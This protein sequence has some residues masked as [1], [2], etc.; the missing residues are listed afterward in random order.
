[1]LCGVL[2]CVGVHVQKADCGASDRRQTGNVPAS[3]HE[4]MIPYVSTGIEQGDEIARTVDA[5]IVDDL[6]S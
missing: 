4:V 2:P 5:V 1:M 6:L 3:E